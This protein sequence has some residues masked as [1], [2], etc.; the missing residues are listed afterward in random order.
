MK[1]YIMKYHD[2]FETLTNYLQ[3]GRNF[4]F[5]ECCIDQFLTHCGKAYWFKDLPHLVNYEGD[6]DLEDGFL[7][8]K[9]CH[10]KI[11]N[12]NGRQKFIDEVNSRRNKTLRKFCS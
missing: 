7:P 10:D 4:G 9:C 3:T 8:C 11:F 5:P 1:S 2:T 6:R 12:K